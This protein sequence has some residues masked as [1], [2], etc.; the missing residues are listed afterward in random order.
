MVQAW[1]IRAL[2]QGATVQAQVQAQVQGPYSPISWERRT[3]ET[4]LGVRQ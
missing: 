3:N 4:A 2:G 1:A